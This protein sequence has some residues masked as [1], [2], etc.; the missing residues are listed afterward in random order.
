[1]KKNTLLAI[2]ITN[3]LGMMFFLSIGQAHTSHSFKVQA[4][5][6]VSSG[7]VAKSNSFTVQTKTLSIG[8]K[9]K[10]SSFKIKKAEPETAVNHTDPNNNSS[11]NSAIN[12]SLLNSNTTEHQTNQA[13]KGGN[14]GTRIYNPQALIQ[15]I[16]TTNKTIQYQPKKETKTTANSQPK[17]PKKEASNKNKT[18]PPVA[19]NK[20][21]KTEK[22]QPKP[23]HKK[24]HAHKRISKS[25]AQTKT[26]AKTDHKQTPHKNF[27]LS[28]SKR[29]NLHFTEPP[30]NKNHTPNEPFLHSAPIQPKAN[31]YCWLYLLIAFF[32]GFTAGAIAQEYRHHPKHWWQKIKPWL[33]KIWKI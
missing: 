21:L 12:H 22:T 29:R 30:Q 26:K 10:S 2:G 33:I 32:V 8:S 17:H 1:M 5:R 6:I 7:S 31:H 11:S 14:G 4:S 24:T 19:K 27:V 3:L 25:T 18:K 9:G 20:P 15:G 13:K 23:R 16:I 28:Q